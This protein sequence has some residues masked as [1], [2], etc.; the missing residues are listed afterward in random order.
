MLKTSKVPSHAKVTTPIRSNRLQLWLSDYDPIKTEELVTGFQEGFHVHFAG[1]CFTRLANNLKSAKDHS[2][3]VSVAIEEG[4]TEGKIAGPFLEIPMH[5]FI[6]SPLGLVPKSTPGEWRLIHHLSYPRGESVNDGIPADFCHVQYEDF[7]YVIGLIA[8]VGPGCWI[9]KADIKSAFHLLPISQ[10]DHGLL[11]FK[12][13]DYFYYFRVASMGCS[14]SCRTF[15]LF[16]CAL[17][18]ILKSKLKVS[19]MSH[20]LD[21]FMFF[22]QTSDLCYEYLCA[23]LALAEDIN[24]PINHQKTVQPTTLAVLHGVEVDTIAMQARLPWDKLEKSKGMIST[25]LSQRTATLLQL[26]KIIGTLNFACKVIPAGRAFLRRLIDLTMGLKAPHHH[27]NITKEAKLDLKTWLLFLEHFNGI[28]VL[29]QT[30]WTD[31]STLRIYTDASNLG[32]GAIFGSHWFQG[33]W[34]DS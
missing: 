18:W 1:S 13:E 5:P 23:F 32:Y 22:G 4:V 31:A 34:L 20:I 6:V 10:E 24:I 16:S 14:S 25:L 19:H 30:S 11:G 28:T 21:D 26:Q 8:D 27:R 3:V 33:K 9:A 7:D 29:Q 15:E 2:H 17:Q 12:W